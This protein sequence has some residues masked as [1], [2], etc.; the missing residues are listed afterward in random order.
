[1]PAG[2][3]TSTAVTV[4]TVDPSYVQ[5]RVQDNLKRNLLILLVTLLIVVPLLS[6]VLSQFIRRIRALTEA[7]DRAS[8]GDMGVEIPV[9]G[10]DEFTDLGRAI[11]RMFTSYKKAES[12][13]MEE[14]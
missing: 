3:S 4:V 10:S 6:Y 8:R 5:K 9:T 11:R 7:A 14:G 13:L 2:G 1:M 12:M